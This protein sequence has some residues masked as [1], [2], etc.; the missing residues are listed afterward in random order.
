MYLVVEY[1]P[2]GDLYSLLDVFGAFDE[3]VAKL[4]TME[5]LEALRYLRSNGIIHRDIKPDN[6]LVSSA[7]TLKLT[8]FGLSHLGVFDR[9]AVISDPS[10][11]SSSSFVGTPDYTAPEIILSKPHS[12]SADYWSLGIMLY[13]FLMGEPPFHGENEEETHTNILRAYV[14]YSEMEEEGFSPEVID[15]LKKL[16]V[17]DPHKRLGAKDINEIINHQWF[18]GVDTKTAEPPFVPE[19][20]TPADTEYFKQRYTFK[21]EDDSDILEDMAD[22]NQIKGNSSADLP[23]FQALSIDQLKEKNTIVAETIRKSKSVNSSDSNLDLT[24][25]SLLSSFS[26]LLPNDIVSP[27]NDSITPPNDIDCPS[28]TDQIQLSRNSSEGQQSAPVLNLTNDEYEYEIVEEEEE[29]DLD[30]FHAKRETNSKRLDVPPIGVMK[31][32][33]INVFNLPVTLKSFSN[34]DSNIETNSIEKDINQDLYH[35]S[36]PKVQQT[37]SFR[38][39]PSSLEKNTNHPYKDHQ[40][41]ILH[42]LQIQNNSSSNMNPGVGLSLEN[43]QSFRILRQDSNIRRNRSSSF[44]KHQDDKSDSSNIQQSSD[45]NRKKKDS[46]LRRVHIFLPNSNN[47]DDFC[48]NGNAKNDSNFQDEKIFSKTELLVSDDEEL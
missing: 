15:L 18:A 21:A 2:G 25:E 29:E 32:N 10:L 35:K 46:S 13:E 12:F 41:R 37:H 17:T 39:I 36:V 40:N 1:L 27:N 24:I 20:K 30:E 43:S 7:G 16:L 23:K 45:F 22:L 38:I 26:V 47:S 31:S 33:S 44:T 28:L 4:Y 8:D 11:A 34:Q 42:M 14:D 5:I 48:E 19:L 9:Q 3:D 6:V